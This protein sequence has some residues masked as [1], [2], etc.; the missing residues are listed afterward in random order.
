VAFTLLALLSAVGGAL[1]WN[2]LQDHND[3]MILV[4]AALLVAVALLLW[5]FAVL[6]WDLFDGRIH[7]WL[8]VVLVTMLTPACALGAAVISAVAGLALVT[9]LEPDQAPVGPSEP[10]AR[11]EPAQPKTTSDEGVS[12]E[13]TTDRTASPSAAPT[14]SPSAAP[15][16]TPS[17]SASPSP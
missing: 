2:L 10:P 4:T 5:A 16:A 17:P 15:S 14:S 11:T 6:L 12:P 8:R 3:E 13:T 7:G 9:A 1:G